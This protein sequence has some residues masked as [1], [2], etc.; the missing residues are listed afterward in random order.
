MRIIAICLLTVDAVVGDLKVR[1][2][3]GRTRMH[4]EYDIVRNAHRA[5]LAS[6]APGVHIGAHVDRAAKIVVTL[7]DAPAEPHPTVSGR[8]DDDD[9]MWV[10]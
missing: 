3:I 7:A 6:R 5:R 10:V 9:T 2:E 1:S 8:P 4:V